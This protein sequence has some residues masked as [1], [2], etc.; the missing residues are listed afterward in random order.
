MRH[1][2]CYFFVDSSPASFDG[3]NKY[4]NKSLTFYE[5]MGAEFHCQ[6]TRST[7]LKDTMKPSYSIQLVFRPSQSLINN[8]VWKF[9]INLCSRIYLQWVN[10]NNRWKYWEV[11]EIYFLRT[12]NCDYLIFIKF[13]NTA[14]PKY[15]AIRN[16]RKLH[17]GTKRFLIIFWRGIQ[18]YMLRLDLGVIEQ[19]IKRTLLQ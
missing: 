5:G 18:K 12:Q 10:F 14:K 9:N 19:R 2:Q 13:W 6:R 7:I 3:S 15:W 4:I 8:K 17:G 11:Y 16:I 1:W